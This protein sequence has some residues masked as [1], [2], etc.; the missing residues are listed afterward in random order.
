MHTIKKQNNKQT[1][2]KYC[3]SSILG[4]DKA[5]N[6]SRKITI[7][8]MQQDKYI[9]KH[10]RLRHSLISKSQYSTAPKSWCS[11]CLHF[12]QWHF[13]LYGCYNLQWRVLSKTTIT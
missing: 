11:N 10:V 2:V 3:F 5:T 7:L 12:S 4:K 13:T 1:Y 9:N 6:H 8:N